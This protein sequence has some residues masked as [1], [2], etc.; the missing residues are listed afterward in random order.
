LGRPTWPAADSAGA[1]IGR[2]PVWFEGTWLD[3]PI[4]DR[5]RLPL[6]ASFEGPAILEQ[7]DSTTVVDPG[8][9]V[10][11]DAAGNLILTVG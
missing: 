11:V 9:R 7:M 4:Y 1:E 10:V 2:R 3:T 6:G 5:A 8:V